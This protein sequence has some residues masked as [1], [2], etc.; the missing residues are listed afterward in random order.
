MV[1]DLIMS[2]ISYKFPRGTSSIPFSSVL[3]E[4]KCPG[5]ENV[6]YL[7][8]DC[9]RYVNLNE[10]RR[11]IIIIISVIISLQCYCMMFRIVLS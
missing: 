6:L 1:L 2:I 9:R 3:R 7:I 10:K 11:E 5:R 4:I 8:Q